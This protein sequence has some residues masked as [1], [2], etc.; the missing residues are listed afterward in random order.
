[1]E[2]ELRTRAIQLE[3]RSVDENP[4]IAGYA[5]VFNESSEDL[6]GFIESIAPNALDEVDL[7]QVLCLYNHDTSNILARSDSGNLT[8]RV[9]NKG[10]YFEATLPDTTLARDVLAN[11]QAGNIKGCS[12]GFTV[13]ETEW[14]WSDCSENL[15]VRRINKIDRLYE[16]TLT[17]IPAYQDTSVSQRTLKVEQ[18]KIKNQIKLINYY[19]EII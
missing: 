19:K 14:I 16:I 4:V 6:G 2:K 13:K 15:D 7:S 5:I 9:D 17:P 3:T 8:L 18:N 12:F 10:L 1:M 11:V